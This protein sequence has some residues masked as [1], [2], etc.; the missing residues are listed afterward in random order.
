MSMMKIHGGHRLMGEVT[1]CGA[2]NSTV[3][4]IPAAILSDSPVEFNSVPDILDVH[5]LMLILQSMNVP[6]EFNDGTFKVNPTNI[7]ES[8]LPS[9]AIKKLRASYYFMGSL[10]GKFH[11]A[12]VSFPGGDNI[13]PRPIDQHIRAFE[14]LGATVT[15][16]GDTVYIDATKHGLKGGIINFDMVSVGATINA[17]LAATKA[18][19]ITLIHNVAKEPE[20]VDIVTFLNS[21]GAKITGAGTDDIRIEGVQSLSATEPH[22]VIPDRIEA[23]TYLALAAAIG[24]GILVKNVIP[25]HLKP[26]TEKL[27]EMGLKLEINDDSIFVP[28]S[29]NI[30][31]VQITTDPFPGFATDWQQPI[32]PL[33]L[34]AKSSSLIIDTIYPKRKKHVHELQKMGANIEVNADN[35]IVISPTKQLHGAVVSAG[36]I[37]AGAA[38]L[39]AGLMADGDTIITHA[40]HI[41]R[42]YDQVVTKLSGLNAD[43]ELDDEIVPA[44][45]EA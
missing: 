35:N 5:N 3:A 24:D 2:K 42:G 31:G 43:V 17:I 20:I 25:E 26:F 28:E 37:R 33:L 6:S 18:D 12:I 32:T 36:E 34:N 10:L 45:A 40:D 4:L 39:I 29:S 15:E 14:A 8:R 1:I 22:T 44:S 38:L 23:G 27:T 21:M 30:Q 7:K 13:G 41:L 19:G 16:D 9:E 11:K